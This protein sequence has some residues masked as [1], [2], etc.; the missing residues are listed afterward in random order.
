MSVEREGF[1]KDMQFFRFRELACNRPLG[2]WENGVIGEKLADGDARLA[3]AR[4]A[5]I[6]G[7]G[8]KRRPTLFHGQERSAHR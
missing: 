8:G 2:N 3:R 5:L 6:V 1:W 4:A 7:V